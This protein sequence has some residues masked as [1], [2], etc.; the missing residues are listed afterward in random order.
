MNLSLE[1]EYFKQQ[2]EQGFNEEIEHPAFEEEECNYLEYKGY[3]GTAN[4][5]EEEDLWYGKVVGLNV[6]YEGDYLN[7]LIEDFH[8]AIDEYLITKEENNDTRSI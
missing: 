4:W 7:S 3:Q 8:A 6:R 1:K 2:K 5:D